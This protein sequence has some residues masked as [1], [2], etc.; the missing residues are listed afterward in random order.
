MRPQYARSGHYW[1]VT[2]VD[3]R[4]FRVIP[5]PLDRHVLNGRSPL[6]YN[7]DGSLTLVFATQRP[8][9]RP[10]PNWLPTLPGGRP[11]APAPVPGAGRRSAPSVVDRAFTGPV[12]R[13]GARARRGGRGL[14]V[15]TA[16]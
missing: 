15:N 13:V 1:S 7:E 3:S 5:N 8:A 10:E 9:G 4:E 16:H 12:C 2:A 14:P 6:E 11:H